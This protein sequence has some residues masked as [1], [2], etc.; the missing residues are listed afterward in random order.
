MAVLIDVI[1]SR[2]NE[3]QIDVWSTILDTKHSYCDGTW[4][5]YWT[6]TDHMPPASHPSERSIVYISA[7]EGGRVQYPGRNDVPVPDRLKRRGYERVEMSPR[8]LRQFEKSHHVV[9]ERMHFDR[10]GRGMEDG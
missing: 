5:R 8:E 4:E 3:V 10:N 6:I 7:K 9:N 1:C 2:C